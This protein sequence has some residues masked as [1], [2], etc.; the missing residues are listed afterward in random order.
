MSKERSDAAKRPV[1]RFVMWLLGRS[2]QC[3]KCGSWDTEHGCHWTRGRNNLCEQAYGDCGAYCNKCS[4][5][6]WD[7]SLEEHLKT[8]EPWCKPHNK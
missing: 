5:V 8:L 1:D 6:T 3:E 4:H 2:H 7:T